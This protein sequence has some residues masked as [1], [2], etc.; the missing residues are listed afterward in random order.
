MAAELLVLSSLRTA[1]GAKKIPRPDILDEFDVR[2][3]YTAP[4]FYVALPSCQQPQIDISSIAASRGNND[5][6]KKSAVALSTRTQRSITG[7]T[8]T[9]RCSQQGSV[10]LLER[11]RQFTSLPKLKILQN[12]HKCRLVRPMMI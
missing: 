12:R 6:N 7:C 2:N 11:N 5:S 3:G 4:F 9:S 1:R 10:R 8:V